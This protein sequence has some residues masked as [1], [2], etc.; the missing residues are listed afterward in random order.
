MGGF[1]LVLAIFALAAVLSMKNME[2]VGQATDEI[3]QLQEGRENGL[4]VETLAR[5]MDAAMAD[6]LRSGEWQQVEVFRATAQAMKAAREEMGKAARTDKERAWLA[7]CS[8]LSRQLEADFDQ[9]FVPAVIAADEDAAWLHRRR[10]RELL[11]KLLGLNEQFTRLQ[12]LK[13]GIALRGAIR[14]RSD[15]VRDSG[16]L[17]A[18]AVL[19]AVLIALLVAWSIATPIQELMKATQAVASGDLT[20]KLDTR[21]RDEFGRLAES[22]NKMSSDLREHQQRLV[23]AEKMASLG[24]IAAGVAH[25]INNPIGVISGFAN[26]MSKD[27][28]LS[29]TMAEDIGVIREEAEQCQRIIQDL[30]DFS[31][32]APPA[33]EVVDLRKAVEELL[34]RARRWPTAAGITLATE[35]AADRLPVRAD[36]SRLAQAMENI[37]RNAFEAMPDGG[38]LHVGLRIIHQAASPAEGRPMAEAVFKD[39]GPGIPPTHIEKIFEPFFSTKEKGTGLGLSIAYAAI[40]AYGGT[41]TVQSE[42]VEGAAFTLRMPLAEGDQEK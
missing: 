31:R 29:A 18:A 19:V 37:V 30:L 7:E 41:L 15:A 34:D 3:R 27:R 38:T 14:V 42:P 12:E 24:R 2:R 1:V 6:L 17:F 4:Q 21:R 10:G 35:F 13:I 22:F 16:L 8:A 28:N 5:R 32:P 36:P 20:R 39:T 33:E 23:Q 40:R 25:E 26:L 9:Y 11:E